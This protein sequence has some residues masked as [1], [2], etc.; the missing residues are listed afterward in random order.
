[1]HSTPRFFPLLLTSL[2]L[3]GTLATAQSWQY[4]EARSKDGNHFTIYD[5]HTRIYYLANE[6]TWF[7]NFSLSG[8]FEREP[9]SLK[10]RNS[11]GSGRTYPLQQDLVE[12]IPKPEKNTTIVYFPIHEGNLDIFKTANSVAL[13]YGDR[14]FHTPLKG[15]SKAITRALDRV[16]YDI[17]LEDDRKHSIAQAESDAKQAKAR[18][19]DAQF[20]CDILSSHPWD[21]NRVITGVEWSDMDGQAA[22]QACE[23]AREL[24]GN[25]ARILYQLARAYDKVEDPAAFK[26]LRNAAWDMNYPAA[27]YHLALLHR[28]GLYTSK[29]PEKA[30]EAFSQGHALGHIPSTYEFGRLNYKSAKTD[31]DQKEALE[32]L[33][34]S[35]RALYPYAL[36]YVGTLLYN[37]EIVGGSPVDAHLYLVEASKLDQAN[38]SYLLSK[39]YTDGTGVEVDGIEA[40]YYLLKAVKQGHKQAKIDWENQ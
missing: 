20:E 34:N 36:N 38:A 21:K 14:T 37:D 13:I 25:K 3:F 39:M 33:F 4:E 6:R 30:L 28:D 18:A 23:T 9:V 27:F 26:L 22:V 1:M 11:D 7:V 35:A 10:F 5:G 24:N 29:D 16:T 8:V 15:S 12:V 17:A 40:N 32:L 31:G 19:D 2:L